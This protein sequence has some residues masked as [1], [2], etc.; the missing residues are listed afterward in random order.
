MAVDRCAV[1]RHALAVALQGQLLQK[2]RKTPER[3]RIRN[4]DPLRVPKHARVPPPD[5]AQ[6]QREIFRCRRF[7]NVFDT[8]IK[9]VVAGSRFESARDRCS[10]STFDTNETSMAPGAAEI[11]SQTSRGP[12]SEPPMPM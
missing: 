3:L 1:A 7:A 10:G 2:R 12:R 5:Q 9:S 8:T 4:D 6:N 11:A